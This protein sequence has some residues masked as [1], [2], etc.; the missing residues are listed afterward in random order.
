MSAKRYAQSIESEFL[1]REQLIA[2]MGLPRRMLDRLIA[3]GELKQ[4]RSGP[5]IGH[6]GQRIFYARSQVEL[7]R[8]RLHGRKRR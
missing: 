3:T 2:L 4:Y 7:L 5:G 1:T 6:G 8:R